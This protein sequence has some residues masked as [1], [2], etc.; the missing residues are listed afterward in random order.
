MEFPASK[1]AIADPLCPSC[2]Q[3]TAEGQR[4][5]VSCGYGFE[6]AARV[7]PYEAPELRKFIDQEGHLTR[8][9]IKLGQRALEKLRAKFPQVTLCT[10]VVNVPE[11]VKLSEFGFWLF[12]QSVPNGPRLVERRMRSILLT[13]DPTRQ[14]A[15]LTL[16]Y[17]L[18]PFITDSS[19]VECLKKIK[20][21]L[22]DHRYG[23][24]LKKLCR[25]LEP[26]F[27]RGFDEAS[28]AYKEQIADRYS[29]RRSAQKPPT[30]ATLE[31]S[32]PQPSHRIIESHDAHV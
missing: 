21:P 5:C 8:D 10:C 6:F 27:E 23:I 17:G 20:K 15:S 32:S 28:H 9:D 3:I 31:E 12:N 1:I 13:I 25:A 18:D 19:L 22:N 7:L 14:E 16:G 26:V 29:E 4:V 11:S 2:G 24:A 30:P